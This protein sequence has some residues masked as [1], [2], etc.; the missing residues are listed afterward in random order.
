MAHKAGFVNI[1]GNPNVGKSTIM[2]ALVGEKLS[3]IT[4]KMQTTRHRIKG[5]VSGDDF[6]IV[7]SDTPGILKPSYKLQETMMKFV[8]SALIDAD[9][10]LFV[11]DV[12]EKPDKNPEYIE[13]VRKSNMPVIVLINKIDLSS[14]EEV[15]KLY[16]LWSNTF[17]GANIFPISAQEKFNIEPIFDRILEL[18][19]ESPAFFPKDEL[20]DRNERFFVQE[21]IREK[22]LLHYQKEIPYAVEVE[23]EEFKE[24]EKIINIRAVIYV[25]RESQKG[26]IIGHQGKMI[27]K[28]GT[29]ARADAEEFFS[30][31]IFLE[32]Y[33][34]VAKDWRE[35]DRQLKKFGYDSF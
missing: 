35:K 19:P 1:V 13:K 14:Q 31:K 15:L 23:V 27:K 3:I 22:I 25:S 28:I 9:V 21:I 32:I 11:T 33:V 6:Q 4:Q 26:I 29:E 20:T 10:I 18:L 30:K 34:K 8:D 5:I 17:P 12:V 2:N 7:Y 24:A 16:D